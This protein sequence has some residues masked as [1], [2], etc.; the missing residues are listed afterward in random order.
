MSQDV[1]VVYRTEP[2]NRMGLAGFI[3]SLL[4]VL[5][6]CFGGALLCPIGLV[7]SAIGLRRPP[8]GFAIAGLVLG[9]LGS[10]W[11]FVA[12]AFLGFAGLISAAA[13]HQIGEEI[14][15]RVVADAVEQYRRD[16]GYLPITL[17]E[18]QTKYP[19]KVTKDHL[20]NLGYRQTD[21]DTFVIIRPGPDN[22]LGTPD[23]VS[24]A[25]PSRSTSTGRGGEVERTPSD[26]TPPPAQPSPGI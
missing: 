12:I 23:D 8:R 15:V 16:T 14:R 10:I 26:P 22:V 19:G 1:R 9:I 17:D 5:A 3:I 20:E 2:T 6:G 25:P 21:V 24:F 13:M 4:G 7:L 11:L 18:L